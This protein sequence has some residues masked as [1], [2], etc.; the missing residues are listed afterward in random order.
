VFVAASALTT[1]QMQAVMKQMRLQDVEVRVSANLPETLSTRIAPQPVGGITTLSV[2]PVRLSGS[3]ATAKRTLDLVGSALALIVL[4]PLFAAIALAIKLTSPGPVLFRQTRVGR[5]GERFT[6]LK[7]RTM[8]DGADE[9]RRQLLDLNEASG[10]LFKIRSDPRVTRFGRWLRKWSLDELPQL[11]NVLRGDMSLVGP[12]PSLPEEAAKYFDEQVDRL[13][14]RPGMTG[15]WQ[16]SGRSD[17][18]F[19]E[20]VRMDLFYIENWSVSYDLF[21]LGRTIP[22]VLA[23]RGSY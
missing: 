3:Q 22:A 18:S 4:S 23:G 5:H 1:A 16:V 15:L 21:I 17:A 6:L 7:F 9:Q 10:P 20:Y 8:V 12:R 11:A 19:D 13:E 14:V 2:R